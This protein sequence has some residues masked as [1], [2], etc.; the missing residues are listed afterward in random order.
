MGLYDVVKEEVE[1]RGWAGPGPP[2]YPKFSRGEGL[3]GAAIASG[4]PVIVQDV[5]TDRRHLPTL[6][7]TRAEA[8]FPVV[9]PSG[10]LGTVDVESA[11]AQA[12]TVERVRWL[13]R[14]VDALAPFWEAGHR[15]G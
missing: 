12:F 9:A 10:V 13:E 4:R 11:N 15:G 14:C 8:I 1:V 2:A 7:G 5:R 6:E 3:T